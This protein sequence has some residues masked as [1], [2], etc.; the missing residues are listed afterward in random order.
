VRPNL[1]PYPRRL[2]SVAVAITTL[3]CGS[4]EHSAWHDGDRT[5]TVARTPPS[6]DTDS[7]P[8][9]GETK[10]TARYARAPSGPLKIWG[11]GTTLRP[12]DGEAGDQFGHV[13]AIG[14][15]SVFVG[16][17]GNDLSKG[18]VYVF[19][20][21]GAAWSQRQKLVA[22]DAAP[23]AQFGWSLAVDG[24]VALVGAPNDSP[25]GAAYVFARS[26]AT[27]LEQKKLTRPGER[28]ACSV[29]LS[30]GTAVVGTCSDPAAAHLFLRSGTTWNPGQTLSTTGTGNGGGAVVAVDGST[31]ILGASY[32]DTAGAAYVFAASGSTWTGQQTLVPT[33]RAGGSAFGGS[34]SIS[35]DTA[36]IGRQGAI[37]VFDRS[38]SAWT[39]RQKLAVAPESLVA[40]GVVDGDRALVSAAAG[41][42]VLERSGTMWSASQNLVSGSGVG[43]VALHGDTAVIGRG[44]ASDAVVFPRGL[45]FGESCS[46]DDECASLH[47]VDGVCCRSSC[48]G[49][50]EA[51]ARDI[52]GTFDGNCS[53]IQADQD[54]EDE[55]DPDPGFPNSCGADGSCSGN[56][57]CRAHARQGTACGSTSCSGSTISGNSCDGSGTCS[58][59]PQSCGAYLCS[60]NVCATDCS[61]DAGCTAASYCTQGGTCAPKKAQ[62]EACSDER[63]CSSGYCVDDTCCNTPCTDA[64]GACSTNTGAAVDG[65]CGELAKGSA[66]GSNLF[67]T[68][69][70]VSSCGCEADGDCPADRYCSVDG[71]CLPRKA[72]GAVCDPAAG[73]DCKESDC[74][75][76]ESAI[77]ADGVCCD[78]LCSAAESCLASRKVSG[79]D[80]TCGEAKTA[81]NGSRCQES[82]TCTSAHCVDGVCCNEKC[83]GTCEACTVALKGGGDDGTCG[84]VEAGT[85]PLDSSGNPDSDGKPECAENAACDTPVVCDESGGCFC[86]TDTTGVPVCDEDGVTILSDTEPPY[87]C[88]PYRCRLGTC[89]PDCSD[90]T[91][92]APGYRC[93][94]DHNCVSS[95][96]GAPSDE[97]GG[98]GCR[99]VHVPPRGS[100]WVATVALALLV[101]RIRR[102]RSK[103]SLQIC[104]EAFPRLG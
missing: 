1:S 76:C 25:D 10:S 3:A 24:D 21:S 33:D 42:V 69:A 13:V 99:T 6:I 61:N 50:C 80:G 77:C 59:V 63:E 56:G 43:P 100:G 75:V 11:P 14:G 92:C 47:C 93:T 83:S 71:T 102:T 18:A 90:A 19:E 62:G 91:D 58:T 41:L 78:H 89:R 38:G 96:A 16:A 84:H 97:G 30:G 53:Y 2:V 52:T 15:N 23:G 37:Y 22:S 45:D 26:G 12:S 40:Q 65:T 82:A 54:P 55:C 35:G 85:N 34:V 64:C 98:C 88:T 7:F 66:C 20:R 57:G 104:E 95:T 39:Q 51:C 9:R 17:F 94:S 70:S 74:R 103:K 67:C 46:A 32:T 48:S 68:G 73:E 72:V 4:L 29:A 28:I 5:E 44:S 8:L 81:V 49:E 86:D 87:Q 36:F 79:D 101:L 27:W 31:A 60:G